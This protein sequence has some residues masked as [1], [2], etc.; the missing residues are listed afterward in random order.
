MKCPYCDSEDSKVTDSR[1]VDNAVRRRRQCLQCSSR[2]T[3]YER[4]QLGNMIVIKKD[5]RRE[6]FN[7]EKLAAGIRRACEK[8]PLPTGTIDRLVDEIETELLQMNKAEISSSTIGEMVMER[9]K[10]LDHI[11]YIRF[12]SVYRQFADIGSL[13]R[14]V[15][16]LVE[17]ATAPA[18][19]Q[20]PL[21]PKEELGNNPP[22]AR[23]RVARKKSRA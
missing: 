16:T 2:F 20:L 10:N 22:P 15:D 9:L 3:T 4:V 12:A 21:L 8:R 17:S 19:G 1:D 18:G 13:K 14:E 5:Q 7:R 11:A 6:E 23:G